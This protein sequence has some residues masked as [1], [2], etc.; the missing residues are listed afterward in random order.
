MLFFYSL[1]IKIA[2]CH[3]AE[4]CWQEAGTISPYDEAIRLGRVNSLLLS[5][6]QLNL[7][8]LRE[9]WCRSVSSLLRD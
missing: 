8:R 6:D 7:K 1:I 2:E 5:K 4:C 9:A 3:R